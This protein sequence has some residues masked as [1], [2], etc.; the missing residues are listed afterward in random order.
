MLFINDRSVSATPMLART[1]D[2]L[3]A[4]DTAV[5][6]ANPLVAQSINTTQCVAKRCHAVNSIH[7]RPNM[8]AVY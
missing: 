1:S 2:H 5:D 7:S 4:Q 6:S 3:P 8:Y